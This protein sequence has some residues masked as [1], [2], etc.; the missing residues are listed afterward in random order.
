M[1]MTHVIVLVTQGQRKQSETNIGWPKGCLETWPPTTEAVPSV[2]AVDPSDTAVSVGPAVIGPSVVPASEDPLSAV[3]CQ[4]QPWI[5]A[6]P[7]S[8][9][10][11][12]GV[13]SWVTSHHH[14]ISQ[15]LLSFD[16]ALTFDRTC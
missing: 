10:P 9:G 1:L 6:E 4:P 16:W 3:P 15:S 11:C 5:H 12:V 14:Q 2:S 13:G 8:K 7:N